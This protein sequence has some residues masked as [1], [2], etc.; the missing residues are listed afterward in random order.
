[1]ATDATGAPTSLGI[2]KYNT[3]ADAPSGIGFNGAM[4]D[5]DALIAARVSKP[6]G[7]TAGDVPVWNGTT[8]VIPTGTRTG[9]KFL[10]DDGSWQSVSPAT[11]ELAYNEFTSN[12]TVNATTEATANTIVTASAVTFD[13]STQVFVEYLI[14]QVDSGTSA[15]IQL[16]M[17][18]YDGASSIGILTQYQDAVAST[19]QGPILQGRRR[20]TPSAAAHTYS[21]RGFVNAQSY[22]VKAGLGGVGVLVPGFIRIARAT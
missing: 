17:V 13:G 3:S 6:A 1:M 20:L 2:R 12:V 7:V 14:P 21:I 9:A 5:I 15:G 18:L 16:Q 10:R 8:W 4:D 22:S 11:N 19:N